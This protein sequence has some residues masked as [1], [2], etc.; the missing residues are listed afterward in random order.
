MLNIKLK[1]ILPDSNLMEE[2]HCSF[3]LEVLR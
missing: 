2:N 3:V 1:S